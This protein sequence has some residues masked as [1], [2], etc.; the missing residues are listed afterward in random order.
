MRA[1]IKPNDLGT[2]YDIFLFQEFKGGPARLFRI[3]EGP[4]TWSVVEVPEG[5]ASPGPS[6]TLD[7]DMLDALREA[8]SPSNVSDSDQITYLRNQLHQERARVD[9]L[10]GV[11]VEPRVVFENPRS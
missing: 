8:L 9:K 7:R 10:I 4:D 11:L 1:A 5:T 2:A 6:F 3:T